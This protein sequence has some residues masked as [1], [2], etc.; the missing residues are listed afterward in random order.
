MNKKTPRTDASKVDKGGMTFVWL[1]FAQELEQELTEKTNEVE[2]L[3]ALCKQRGEKI[4][5]LETQLES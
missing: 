3:R 4:D 2:R 5:E 1:E